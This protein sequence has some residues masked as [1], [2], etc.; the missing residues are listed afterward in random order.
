MSL[1]SRSIL[2]VDDEPSICQILN[3]FL[4]RHGFITTIANSGSQAFQ[5]LKANK[6]DLILC[7][8]NLG[9]IVGVEI[10][11]KVRQISPETIIIFISGYGDINTAVNL[12]KDGAYHFLTKPLYPDLILE[13]INNSLN[14]ARPAKKSD[15]TAPADAAPIPVTYIKGNSPAAIR[16]FQHINLVAPTTYNVIIH[17]DTGT[18]K[19]ALAHFLHT[20][21]NRSSQPFIAIDCGS[22]SKELAASELFGHKKGA[23]TGAMNDKKGAFELA[24]GGTLFLDEIGNLPYEVQNYLLRALQEKLIRRV[25]DI[26]EVKVDVRVIVASNENLQELVQQKLFREDL[27]H[28][29]NEFTLEVPTLHERKPDLPLFVDEFIK[30]ATHHLGKKINGLK[31]EVKELFDAYHW[32]GNIRELQNVIKRA[33]LLTEANGFIDRNSLPLEIVA[34]FNGNNRHARNEEPEMSAAIRPS[35]GLKDVALEAERI[36]IYKVLE[37]VNYNKTKAAEILEIDRKT[38]YNKLKL[39]KEL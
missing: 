1:T 27:Y 11:N 24:D 34:P 19:E 14:Q 37:K 9:D 39:M 10:L 38:L 26:L 16:L 17:G 32:P 5:L 20:G 21:S 8:Y 6:Y 12:I 22:L 33:C 28:R 18:G 23:F 30:Q 4:K 29:L 15:Q 2:I 31:E 25:G 13:T 3:Q 36:R 35:S 7:D